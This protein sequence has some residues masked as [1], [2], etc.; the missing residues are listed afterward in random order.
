LSKTPIIGP[1]AASVASSWIDMLAGLSKKYILR[2]PPC[3]CAR[4]ELPTINASG[5]SHATAKLGRYRF[6]ALSSRVHL[7][8]AGSTAIFFVGRSGRPER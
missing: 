1:W 5:N 3:F 8:L 6:I 2:T 4:A 7:R